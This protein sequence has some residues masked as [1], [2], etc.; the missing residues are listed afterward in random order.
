MCLMDMMA[1]WAAPLDYHLPDNAGEDSQSILP[2]LLGDSQPVRDDLIHH[3]VSGMFALRE[4]KWKMIF[5]QG[6]GGFRM[7]ATPRDIQLPGQLYD[8]QTDLQ[9]ATDHWAAHPDL[10]TS[11]MAKLARYRAQGFSRRE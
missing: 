7:L 3:S 5:G 8:L 11:L 6:D 4:G 2:L 9:E 10:Q 1:T